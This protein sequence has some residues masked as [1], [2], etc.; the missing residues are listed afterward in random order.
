MFLA[1]KCKPASSFKS[2]IMSTILFFLKINTFFLLAVLVSLNNE[3]NTLEI[4]WVKKRLKLVL[5][6]RGK[7]Y[8][9]RIREINKS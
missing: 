5:K 7:F 8:I 6:A 2:R 4:A 3:D 9:S 1:L